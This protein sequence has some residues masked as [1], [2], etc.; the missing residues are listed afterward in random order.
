MDIVTDITAQAVSFITTFQDICHEKGSEIR[1]TDNLNAALWDL[2]DFD[3]IDDIADKGNLKDTFGQ[4]KERIHEIIWSSRGEKETD[5]SIRCFFNI[6]KNLMSKIAELRDE[7]ADDPNSDTDKDNAAVLGSLHSSPYQWR[8]IIRSILYRFPEKRIE[9]VCVLHYMPI[10]I[11]L[12][13]G[14]K[15]LSAYRQRLYQIYKPDNKYLLSGSDREKNESWWEMRNELA[16]ELLKHDPMLL[17]GLL[18]SDNAVPFETLFNNELDE[19]A[20]R[21]EAVDSSVAGQSHSADP[22]IR[23]KQME[24]VGL[25]LSGGGIR[26]ASFNLGLIQQLAERNHLKRIDY[27]STVSGG[28]YIGSWLASWI[29]RMGSISKLTARLNPRK[30]ADPLADEV[31]PIRWLRMYSNFLAPDTSIMSA[32]SWTVGITWLRNTLINQLI[33]LLILCSGLSLVWVLFYFW[34]YLSETPGLFLENNVLFWSSLLLLPG[35]VLAGWGINAYYPNRP[36]QSR[37]NLVRHHLVAP[38]IVGW[39]IVAS[40]LVSCW[41]YSGSTGSANMTYREHVSVLMPAV[42]PALI[43]MLLVAWLGKYRTCIKKVPAREYYPAIILSSLAAVLGGLLLIAGLWSLFQKVDDSKFYYPWKRTEKVATKDAPKKAVSSSDQVQACAT[44]GKNVASTLICNKHL[45][46][47]FGMPA[48]LEVLGIIIVIRMLLMGVLF[49]DERREWWGRMGAVAH[50]FM[51]LWLL[52]SSSVFLLPG[53]IAGM[54]FKYIAGAW[55][56]II[57]AA[58]RLAYSSSQAEASGKGNGLSAKE[59]F[60]RFAPYLFMF[61]SLLIGVYVLKNIREVWFKDPSS[62]LTLAYACLLSLALMGITYLLSWRVG[63][64]EFSLHHF[65]R[66]RLVRAFLGATRRQADRSKTANGFTGF[67]KHDDIKLSSLRVE[68]GY[69]G[70]YPLINTAMNSTVMSELDRQDRKAEAFVFSPLFTGFDFSPTRSAANYRDHVYEYGYRQ[71]SEYGYENGPSLGTAMAISGA[72]ANPNMGYHSSA[73]TAFLLTVFNVRLGWWIGNPRLGRWRRSDPATGLGYILKDLLGKS[74]INSDYVCLSDGGHFDNMGLYE[75]VR[76]RC[77]YILLS[78]AEGDEDA[79][80]EGLANAIRRCRIDFG[81]EIR[82]GT[83]PI[84]E[85]DKATGYSAMRAVEGLIWY[86]G[87]ELPSG[88]L[89]YVKTTLTKNMPTDIRE[90]HLKNKSFP[91]QTTADQFFDENQFESYRKLGYHALDGVVVPF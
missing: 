54:Y 8:R 9:F 11:I 17:K 3:K 25:A 76:R 18:T 73:A 47:I 55:T 82:I 69:Q 57:G 51:I 30:S 68:K 50:R 5:Q 91:N 53:L 28:G 79:I 35:A 75:L 70:P 24:L 12:S 7:N 38:L 10:Q 66:N 23:A 26:S 64:N 20:R 58:V 16:H 48:I 43:A 74:D 31:R 59:I 2:V 89:L 85:K 6:S 78:D 22:L 77:K 61:G 87:D 39:A 60:I 62:G 84:T 40:F 37:L 41:I 65:Y 63:V 15:G 81:V 71:T 34:I 83:E 45:L 4:F 42:V 86:P 44:T 1:K 36:P 67:D 33:L 29:M 19:V 46:F 80:C 49:P 14:G 32:D 72:A 88:K 21:R 56:V 27:L 90:Y 52:I 13:L